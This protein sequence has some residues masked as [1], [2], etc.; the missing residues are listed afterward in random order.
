[1]SRPDD[2]ELLEADVR[3]SAPRMSPE[4][5]RRLEA[6]VARAPRAS[7]RARGWRPARAPGVGGLLVAVVAVAVLR[8]RD[9]AGEVAGIP[10]QSE[11][12]G[13]SSAGSSAVATPAPR[14]PAVLAPAR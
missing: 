2:L 7:W 1:M 11:P 8:S 6:I 9:G 10:R 14:G 13:S 5:E 12:A 3:A 4:L